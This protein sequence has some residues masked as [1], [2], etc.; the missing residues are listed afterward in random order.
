MTLERNTALF[1]L[2]HSTV[3]IETPSGKRLLL[4]PFTTS[5]PRCPDAYKAPEALGPLDAILLTHIHNDHCADVE[6]ILK[7]YPDTPVVAIPEACAWVSGKGAKNTLPMNKGGT[8]K[9]AG[10][11]VTMT[12]AIH[13][14]SFS[15]ADGTIIYGGEPAGYILKMENNFTL[16]AAGDT[17]LF[18]DMTL[19]RDLY[20]PELAL[21]PIG[22]HYTMGPRQA[23]H[24]T[25][26]LGVRH[27]LPIHYAT[28]PVLVGTPEAFQ[29][30]LTGS[31]LSEVIVQALQPGETL[32]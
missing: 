25:R 21:L 32:R 20:Q 11:E 28:F 23:A 17:A 5:N 6:S 29:Q 3:L 1:Y 31:G 16:Y 18:S 2:G 22:D 26:L 7:V 24:A 14:S 30:H 27:V 13:S 8:Q 15:E 10:I 9:V 19:L 4:D 12:H